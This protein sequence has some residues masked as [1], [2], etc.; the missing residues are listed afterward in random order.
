MICPNP[1]RRFADTALAVFSA[2]LPS[3]S[4]EAIPAKVYRI[5]STISAT[6]LSEAV[7]STVTGLSL[8]ANHLQLRAARRG[9]LIGE[10][11][12][13]RRNHRRARAAVDPEDTVVCGVR[14]AFRLG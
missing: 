3:I 13:T 5:S 11:G 2:D 10:S 1:Y 7:A 8:E 9:G 4:A 14:E 6:V 12:S